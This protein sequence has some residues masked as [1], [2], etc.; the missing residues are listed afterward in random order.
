VAVNLKPTPLVNKV[1]VKMTD[2]RK[3]YGEGHVLK[4]INLRVTGGE[5]IVVC[6]PSGPGK[7]K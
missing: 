6:G 1:A 5:K 7:S 4:D 2:V 3:W